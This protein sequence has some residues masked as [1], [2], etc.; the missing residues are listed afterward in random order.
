[1]RKLFGFL[2]ILLGIGFM[3][4]SFTAAAM[5]LFGPFPITANKSLPPTGFTIARL[6]EL[7]KALRELIET[8]ISM[9]Q[10]LLFAVIGLILIFTGMRLFKRPAVKRR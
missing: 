10:W 3:V 8:V 6:I 4:L 2:L 7:F 1:M 5:D 9:P